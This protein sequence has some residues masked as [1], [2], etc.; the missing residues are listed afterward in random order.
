METNTTLK[1]LFLETFGKGN[2]EMI[3]IIHSGVIENFKHTSYEFAKGTAKRYVAMT[4]TKHLQ[5]KTGDRL[6]IIR[7]CMAETP[8]NYH[9]L[10]I[11]GFQSKKMCE[12]K[13]LYYYIKTERDVHEY[14][15]HYACIYCGTQGIKNKRESLDGEFARTSYRPYDLLE[16]G[17][18]LLTK[19]TKSNPTE[20]EIK[21]FA[22][23]IVNL[24]F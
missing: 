13:H 24:A 4:L 21:E 3:K 8:F 14:D 20:E 11:D 6:N 1:D 10:L 17:K 22:S 2:E 7:S 9:F 15:E 12:N 19:M 23:T 16:K 18:E 5:E